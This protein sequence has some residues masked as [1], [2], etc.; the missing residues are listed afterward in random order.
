MSSTIS[1]KVIDGCGRVLA[2]YPRARGYFVAT[3][4]E[5]VTPRRAP[6]SRSGCKVPSPETTTAFGSP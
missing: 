1:L 4:P 5:F 6:R 3:Q 2:V